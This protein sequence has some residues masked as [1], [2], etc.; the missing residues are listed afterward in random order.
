[1]SIEI[2]AYA[3]ALRDVQLRQKRKSQ[4]V[5]PSRSPI[6]GPTNA[7]RRAPVC[8]PTSPLALNGSDSWWR[9]DTNLARLSWPVCGRRAG[10][11][12]S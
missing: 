5:R 7:E 9:G 3:Q 4:R 10:A 2:V 8:H 6:S 12:R 11:V 1:M